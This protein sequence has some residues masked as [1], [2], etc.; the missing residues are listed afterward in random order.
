VLQVNQGSLYPA[1]A[2]LEVAGWLDARWGV[3]ENKPAGEVH[4]L[5][6]TGRKR[7]EE[8]TENWE[9]AFRRG[10]PGAPGRR[11]GGRIMRLLRT[12]RMKVS[13]AISPEKVDREVSREIAFHLEMR[14]AQLVESGTPPEEAR[15][16]AAAE[17]GGVTQVREQCRDSRGLPALE[18]L[19][20]D[21]RYGWRMIARSPGSALVAVVTLGLGI[22]IN[23][24]FFS[25]VNAILLRP[26]PFARE[27]RLLLLR[28]PAPG[29]GV[30]NAQFSP[31]EVRDLEAQSRTL[32]AVAEYHN[33]EFTLLGHGDP[34]RVRTGVV[35]ASFFD[36]LGVRPALGRTFRRGEDGHGAAPVL[37]ISH[38]F[39]QN[40]L[41]GDPAI[42]GK[43]FEITTASIPSSACSRLFRN[44]RTRTTCTCRCRHARSGPGPSGTRPGAPTDSRSSRGCGQERRSRSRARSCRS[45]RHA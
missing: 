45:S 25:A 42:V 12:L 34:I 7:L 15:R 17:F 20:Q 1:L 44:T 39:W 30:E 13:G 18:S 16:I 4:S 8:E 14:A 5:T 40:T 24:A 11:A 32:D 10:Q 43:T 37:V 36:L 29:A 22:G 3:S 6:K 26:L 19:A 2:R 23:A 31:P 9:A 35:S 33:M 38:D 21:V 41:G 28:Q 27:N